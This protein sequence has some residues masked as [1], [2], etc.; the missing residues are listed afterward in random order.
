MIGNVPPEDLLQAFLSVLQ[1]PSSRFLFEN[2]AGRRDSLP[3]NLNSV[4]LASKALFFY[5][6]SI[7]RNDKVD[8]VTCFYGSQIIA[9][10]GLA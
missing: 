8:I 10:A 1:L 7:A 4:G 2:L 5:D 6:V 9:I 3:K